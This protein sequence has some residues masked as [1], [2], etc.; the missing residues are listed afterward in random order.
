MVNPPQLDDHSATVSPTSLY[1]S[2]V[3]RLEYLWTKSVD[4]LESSSSENPNSVE[5]F[6]GPDVSFIGRVLDRISWILERNISPCRLH[7]TTVVSRLVFSM[8]T[9]E[10]LLR[11]GR[12]I[13]ESESLEYRSGLR[14][15]EI[16]WLCLSIGNLVELLFPSPKHP[17]SHTYLPFTTYAS[18][19]IRRS[20][21][22]MILLAPLGLLVFFALALGLN[23]D[24]WRIGLAFG[25]FIVSISS[26]GFG[27]GETP[28][29]EEPGSTPTPAD[30]GIAPF[31]VRLWLSITL[32]A[33][34]W[35]MLVVGC[36]RGMTAGQSG[37]RSSAS[38]TSFAANGNGHVEGQEAEEDQWVK[39]WGKGIG[40]EARRI[41][42]RTV[43]DWSPSSRSEPSLLFESRSSFEEEDDERAAPLEETQR[44]GVLK[45]RFP[46]PFNVIFF[47]LY[48]IPSF[49]LSAFCF[50]SASQQTRVRPVLDSWGRSSE[51]MLAKLLGGLAFGWW[52]GA[53]WVWSKLRRG[54]TESARGEITL[55]GD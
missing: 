50:I 48:N 13:P 49:F 22:P 33:I 55:R 37:N 41:R 52:D 12:L 23:G 51:K 42:K 26:S 25:F 28:A 46:S 35:V 15:E 43:Q 31:A 1:I 36:A 44:Q 39:E 17:R 29:G 47:I 21:G 54:E 40:L 27:P 32:V 7:T 11:P 14:F 5:S 45:I 4:I 2:S 24:L 30:P 8:L 3:G 16:L 18:S 53:M 34:L 9:T 20:F 10:I 38:S 19:V 6:R